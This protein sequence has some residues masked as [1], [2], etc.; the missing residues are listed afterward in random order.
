MSQLDKIEEY[1]KAAKAR[2]AIEVVDGE[3][4]GFAQHEQELANPALD[5]YLATDPALHA[6]LIELEQRQRDAKPTEAHTEAAR[7]MFEANMNTEAVRECQWLR[8][9]EV[10]SFVPGRMMTSTQFLA[11]L[12]KIRPDAFYNDFVILGRRGLN[13][14]NPLRLKPYFVTTVQNGQ[15]IEWSQM[16]VDEHNIPT[17]EKYHGWRAVL[18]TLIEREI[19]TMEQADAVFDKPTGPRSDRW[20]RML[21][22]MRNS[23]CPECLKQQCTCKTF[24]DSLRADKYAYQRLQ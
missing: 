10:T 5:Q 24:G 11:L 20:Y 15:M 17:N 1:R 2:G 18:M 13:V 3:G 19:I 8:Q 23:R 22:V 4:G 6:Q 14:V 16:R 21:Y 9:D 12:R 7:A